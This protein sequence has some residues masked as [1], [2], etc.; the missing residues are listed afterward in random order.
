[1]NASFARPEIHQMVFFQVIVHIITQFAEVFHFQGN[2]QVIHHMK[3]H[4][5]QQSSKAA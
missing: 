2:N 3:S 5:F 1:M 4:P